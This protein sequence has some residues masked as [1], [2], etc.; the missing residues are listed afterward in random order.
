MSNIRARHFNHSGNLCTRC[1][2]SWGFDLIFIFDDQHVGIVHSTGLYAKKYFLRPR[3]RRFRDIRQNQRLG[4]SDC[5]TEQ[6]LHSNDSLDRIST[7]EPGFKDKAEIRSKTTQIWSL[8][9][10]VNPEK[11]SL[12]CCVRLHVH[13]LQQED[14]ATRLFQQCRVVVSPN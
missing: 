2:R 9:F 12:I 3:L 4:A 6:S 13:F 11:I 10:L 5:S 8:E 14:I 1:E 7:A